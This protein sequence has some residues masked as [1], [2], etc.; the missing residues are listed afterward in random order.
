METT[1]YR[2]YMGLNDKDTK[3]QEHPTEEAFNLFQ[4]L[5]LRQFDGATVWSA[6]G[7]YTHEDGTQVSENTLCCEL[8]FA[9]YVHVKKFVTLLKEVFNQE[10]IAVQMTKVESDLW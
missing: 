4:S 3:K 2:L 10:S 7:I 6:K 5:V 1:V 9:D 8:I